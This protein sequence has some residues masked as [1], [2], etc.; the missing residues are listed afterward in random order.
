MAPSSE[1][2]IAGIVVRA[3]WTR[4]SC[5]AIDRKWLDGR[6]VCFFCGLSL[7]RFDD[8]VSKITRFVRSSPGKCDIKEVFPHAYAGNRR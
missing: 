2:R 4:G 5:A 8:N 7:T 3:V 6:G 1:D